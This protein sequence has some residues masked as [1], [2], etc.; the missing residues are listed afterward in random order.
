MSSE[1]HTS[2]IEHCNS[3]S[4]RHHHDSSSPATTPHRAIT[5]LNITY[6]NTPSEPPPTSP[7]Q[8]PTTKHRSKPNHKINTKPSPERKDNNTV[9]KSVRTGVGSNPNNDDD[10][11]RGSRTEQNAT[12][13]EGD[14]ENHTSYINVC[15]KQFKIVLILRFKYENSPCNYPCFDFCPCKNNSLI[16]D[17]PAKSQNF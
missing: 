7:P 10:K 4:P 16:L 9:E 2:K 3:S 12:G 8:S 1:H 6:N 11:P 5:V 14:N 17:V 15:P 13:R